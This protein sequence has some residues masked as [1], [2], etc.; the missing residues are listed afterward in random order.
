[1][2]RNYTRKE[3]LGRLASLRSLVRP[4]G[5]KIQIGADIIV[6]FP[7]ETEENFHDTMNLIDSHG[8][9]QLHAFPFS[10]HTNKYHVPA[11]GYAEQIPEHIK[12][13]RLRELIALGDIRKK[14]YIHT[15]QSM[16]LALLLEGNPRPDSFRGW[17]QNYIELSEANFIPEVGSTFA[18]GEILLGKLSSGVNMK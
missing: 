8:I 11:G 2:R 15:H 14:E 4:D 6:G 16:Q 17:S 12:L 10:A 5:V 18:K 13:K 7:G 1:M 9:T 3:L